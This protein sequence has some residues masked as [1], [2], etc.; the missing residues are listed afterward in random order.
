MFAWFQKLL[1]RTGNFFNQFEAH[2]KTLVAS[3]RALAQL[4]H[5]GPDMAIHI[6]TIEAEEHKADEIIREVLQD[7]RRI[8]L[9]PF[10][11][12]AI[13]ALINA[14][15]DA[16][17]QMHFTAGVVELYDVTE[18]TPEMVGMVEIIGEAAMLID[19]ALPLLRNITDN[20]KQLHNFTNRLVE[21]E[22]EADKLNFRGSR[23]AFINHGKTN[24]TQF[25]VVN[26]IYRHLEKVCD[27]CEDVANQ[28]DGLVIDHA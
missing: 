28:I 9:T 11:R 18:F 5:G 26:E 19:Q 17:D 20:A 13:T 27:R 14:M 8:F 2:S 16:V 10:D 6:K 21:L 24:P 7:V 1:P 4:V 25:V 23:N 22:D 15:D 3:S 12:G